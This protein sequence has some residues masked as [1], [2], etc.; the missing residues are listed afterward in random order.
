M[1]PLTADPDWMAEAACRDA[2]TEIFYPKKGDPDTAHWVALFC[3]LCPVREQCLE[4]AL[5]RRERDGI[6]GGKTEK[7]RRRILRQRN[8]ARPEMARRKNAS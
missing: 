4:Y 2:P 1:D 3:G 7:Q 8:G 5:A 6:W